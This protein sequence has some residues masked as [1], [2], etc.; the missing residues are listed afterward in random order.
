MGDD[1]RTAFSGEREEE[2]VAEVPEV[3]RSH[4]HNSALVITGDVMG[5]GLLALPH[6]TARLGWLLGLASCIFF[7]LTALYSGSLLSRVSN[8]MYP[9]ANSYADVALNVL[10]S[11][12][13]NFT[14]AS[15][16]ATWGLILPYYIIT[17][18][19]SLQLGFPEAPLCFWQWTLVV[20]AMLLP[21]LQIRTLHTI[22]YLSAASTLAVG[23]AA[24]LVL[25][26]L[27]AS[28]AATTESLAPLGP[29]ARA[30]GPAVIGDRT[31]GS[32]GRHR[33][34]PIGSFLNVYSSLGSFI[35]AYQGQ[36]MFLEIIREMREPRHFP[37]AVLSATAVMLATYLTVII[38]GYAVLGESVAG[39]LPD[40]L[41]AG[42][43]KS[44]VGLL[45]AFHVAVA[46]L[47][48]G[49][50]LHRNLHLLLFTTSADEWGHRAALHWL[51]ITLGQLGFGF[52]IANVVPFFSDFQNLLGSL[53]GAPILFGWPA[54]FF[55]RGSMLNALPIS[56]ADLIMCSIFLVLFL[57]I[58]TVLGTV[59]AV[60]DIAHDWHGN[61][62]A[63]PFSC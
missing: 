34:Y 26:A 21:V 41:E 17:C 35:F 39:F 51:L 23:L 25:G 36:S 44:A 11:R 38:V 6:A 40:S 10:G 5:T 27:A 8:E 24:G 49:Q 32:A 7:A 18:A 12:F 37:R 19:N 9:E 61:A 57:P 4:W 42:P 30:D 63:A 29:I 22:S 52:G 28:A 46:Y 47:I 45:L 16:L 33:L 31:I 20:S 54:L 2:A 53:T 56:R 48:T 43:L 1:A 13:A 59:N 50:P 60:L 62:T 3:K 14:R 55:L 15:V 58:F